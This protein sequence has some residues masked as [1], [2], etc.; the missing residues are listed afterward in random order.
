M[1]Y[2]FV[3]LLGLTLVL[4]RAGHVLGQNYSSAPNFYKDQ[5]QS[6]HKHHNNHEEGWSSCD[7][8]HGLLLQDMESPLSWKCFVGMVAS[9]GLRP[10]SGAVLVLLIAYSLDLRWARIGAVLAMSLGT[11][12]TVSL[13]ATLSV[14]ARKDALRLASLIPSSAV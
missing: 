6:V 13:L 11:T 4:S 2:G 1:S 10:C 5:S 12:I 3:A 14:Y 7:H 9:I 8:H